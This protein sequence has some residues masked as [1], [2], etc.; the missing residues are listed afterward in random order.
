MKIVFKNLEKSEIAKDAVRERI[1][2]LLEKF[3]DLKK[4]SVHVTLEMHNSPLQAGPDSFSISLRVSGGKYDGVSLTKY[5][6]SL[7]V[8]L[9]DLIE[10]AL[11]IL[12]RNSDKKRVVERS[13]HRKFLLKN[14][15]P[16]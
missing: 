5:S 4:S 1:S 15:Q 6:Q 12:N 14:K 13:M 8:A 7:Y 10:H 2:E 16:V 9:A 11:E 3:P